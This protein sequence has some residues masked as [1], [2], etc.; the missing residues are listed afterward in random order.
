MGSWLPSGVS[1]LAVWHTFQAE[2][3]RVFKQTHFSKH[4]LLLVITRISVR[5]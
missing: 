2:Q 4:K 5:I 1:V 3:Y